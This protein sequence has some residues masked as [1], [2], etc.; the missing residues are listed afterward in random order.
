MLHI[1]NLCSSTKR[2]LQSKHCYWQKFCCAILSN[3]LNHHTNDMSSWPLQ[4]RN[5]LSLTVAKMWRSLAVVSLGK[6]T[7]HQQIQLSITVNHKKK[8]RFTSLVLPH[9]SEMAACTTCKAWLHARDE[10]GLGLCHYSELLHYHRKF[11]MRY[12]ELWQENGIK[13]KGKVWWWANT[14]CDEFDLWP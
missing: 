7:T 8:K 5:W 14:S 3:V 9:S 1:F 13:V 4:S 12:L 2:N 10:S 6:Y 11:R